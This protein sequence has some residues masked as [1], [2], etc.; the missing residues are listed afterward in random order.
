MNARTSCLTEQV[1]SR[2]RRGAVESGEELAAIDAHLAQC[3][4]FREALR[5][6][7]RTTPTA[8]PEKL[9]P[10]KREFLCLED[11]LLER[12][13]EGAVDETD[14]EVVESHLALCPRCTEDVASLRAFRDQMRTYD[15]TA[16]KQ[17]AKGHFRR[18]LRSAVGLDN[19]VGIAAQNFL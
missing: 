18:K 9:L 11:D 4:H 16:A 13:V 1:L 7:I 5:A 6:A 12:Y 19:G 3:P 15:W 2:Y 17:A 10:N 14:R 8:L